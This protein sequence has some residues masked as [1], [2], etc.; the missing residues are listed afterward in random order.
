MLRS[1]WFVL[2]FYFIFLTFILV[3]SSQQTIASNQL[4]KSAA[5]FNP[6]L[7]Q[8]QMPIHSSKTATSNAVSTSSA[9]PAASNKFSSSQK[10]SKKQLAK[11]YEMQQ[12][13]QQQ[14]MQQQ[15]QQ[16]QPS[17]LGHFP[18]AMNAGL[19]SYGATNP[20][21]AAYYSA[22]FENAGLYNQQPNLNPRLGAQPQSTAS[23]GHQLPAP[24]SSALPFLMAAAHAAQQQQQQQPHHHNLSDLSLNNSQSATATNLSQ[25]FHQKS[26]STANSQQANATLSGLIAKPSNYSAQQHGS[27][28]TQVPIS[29]LRM[30]FVKK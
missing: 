8:Q 15:Q 2:F 12:Q 6:G 25:N 24:N 7:P 18:S 28:P 5:Q 23:L 16:Q 29:S 13:Q 19:P 1:V 10:H 26:P 3:I 22:F 17:Q 27:G 30:M 11:E 20:A 14:Q 4:N 21:A 9:A